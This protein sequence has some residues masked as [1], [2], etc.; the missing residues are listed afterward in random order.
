MSLHHRL[1]A[2][3]AG[4]TTF[5]LVAVLVIELLDFE[6]SAIVGLPVGLLAGLAVLV[7][8]WRQFT[9]LDQGSRR[10][11][12][13]YAAFGLTILLLLALTYVNIGRDVFSTEAIVGVGVAAAVITYVGLWRRDSEATP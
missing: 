11:A 13:A 9:E 12:S 4:V 5:L 7:I 2:I 6:F 1:T 3:G 10:I 8:L